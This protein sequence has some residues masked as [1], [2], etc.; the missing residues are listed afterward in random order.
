MMLP[1]GFVPC[2]EGPLQTAPELGIGILGYGF[3]GK[4][5]SH[6]Y[7]TIPHMFWPP[8]V[9]QKL[10]AMCGRSALVAEAVNRYGYAGYYAD[11]KDMVQDPRIDV[12]DNT[13]PYAVHCE[14][15]VAAAQAGKHVLCE[16]PLGLG[17][18]ETGR[19][20]RAV[21]Q[22]GVKHMC[23]FNYRF[24]PAVRLAK[25]IIDQGLLGQILHFRGKYL[26]DM[27]LQPGLV[28]AH[29]GGRRVLLGLG[30]HII[31]MARFLIGE[32]RLVMGVLPDMGVQALVQFANGAR[33]ILEA[34]TVCAGNKNRQAWEIHGTQGSLAWYLEDPNRL[35]VHLEDEP[36]SD[37]RGFRNILV[38]EATHPYIH[39]GQLCEADA[40]L[41]AG[42]EKGQVW[43]P[44][45]HVLGWEHGHVNAIYHFLD[46]VAN[47]R[48]VGPYGATFA[49]GHRV[50]VISDAIERSFR[51]QRETEVD[52]QVCGD[53]GG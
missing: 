8:T 17:S 44:P 18:E 38:T 42:R 34:N 10:V 22:A 36:R 33:G 32:I 1:K 52:D 46:A 30:S 41:P 15:C 48:P 14:P 25:D 49:D 4:A 16:K 35:H 29:P 23:C 21:R 37:L 3:M 6:A 19:M 47:G 2:Q 50:A 13:G 28:A 7:I 11:W 27:G 51:E 12:F 40:K 39:W 9:R 53:A 45:G 31:D 20:L 5:H 24:F 26:Q 43:W